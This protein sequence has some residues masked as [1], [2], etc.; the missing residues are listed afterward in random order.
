[1]SVRIDIDADTYSASKTT[2]REEFIIDPCWDNIVYCLEGFSTGLIAGVVLSIFKSSFFW[3]GLGIGIG[4][5]MSRVTILCMES[6]T[7]SKNSL[8]KLKNSIRDFEE[9]YPYLFTIC[10][11][12]SF[13]IGTVST[14]AALAVGGISAYFWEFLYEEKAA[15]EAQA[16]Y[17]RQSEAAEAEREQKSY[18]GPTSAENLSLLLQKYRI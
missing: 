11:V 8:K 12:S 5:L 16:Y 1:M 10:F 18:A 7:D 6:D 3:G 14:Y 15:R 13:L 2:C 17:Q 4:V 9:D